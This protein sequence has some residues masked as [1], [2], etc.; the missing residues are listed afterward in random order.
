MSIGTVAFQ[1]TEEDKYEYIIGS[2][3]NILHPITDWAMKGSTTPQVQGII[4]L[5]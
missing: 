3:I 2:A 4:T 1:L 5:G